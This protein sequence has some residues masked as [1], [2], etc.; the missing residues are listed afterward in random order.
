MPSRS[1]E[2]AATTA[3]GRGISP[4]RLAI[5]RLTGRPVSIVVAVRIDTPV[6]TVIAAIRGIPTIAGAGS[7]IARRSPGTVGPVITACCA[8]N[9]AIGVA[10]AVEGPQM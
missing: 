7:I 4:Y 3:G 6:I 10:A 8:R 2:T 9:Q 5:A 1:A